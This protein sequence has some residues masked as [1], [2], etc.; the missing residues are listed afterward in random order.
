MAKILVLAF[1]ILYLYTRDFLFKRLTGCQ[2]PVF[3]GL[4]TCFEVVK[5]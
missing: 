5:G 4:A 1:L 2:T 3:I